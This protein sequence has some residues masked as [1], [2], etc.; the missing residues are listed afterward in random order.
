MVG[1]EQYDGTVRIG[2]AQRQDLR[3]ELTDLARGEVH[4]RGDLPADQILR[5]VMFGDLGAGALG[6]DGR[7]K[8]DDE[9][10]RRFPR[11]GERL[12]GDHRA[13][14]DVDGEELVEADRGGRRGR[15][16]VSHMH[17]LC[18]RF[19]PSAVSADACPPTTIA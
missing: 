2:E 9:L 1:A 8:I 17:G 18:L 13:D 4:H 14:P 15:R 5:P 3:E 10:D 11:L 16:I 12:G 19:T 7:T 6:A